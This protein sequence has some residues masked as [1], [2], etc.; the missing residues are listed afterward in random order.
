MAPPLHDRERSTL[1]R[2]GSLD[3]L[4]SVA[5][6]PPA[7]VAGY[8]GREQHW[9]GQCGDDGGGW[10]GE[11]ERSGSERPRER[12]GGGEKGRWLVLGT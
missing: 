5:P 7:I 2:R 8:A 12:A 6:L 1:G 9:G 4:P 10:L 3:P 11:R